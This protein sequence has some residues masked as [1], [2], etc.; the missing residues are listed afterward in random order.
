[1]NDLTP[2]Q[3]ARIREIIREELD[4]IAAERMDQG[5]ADARR[6]AWMRDD[7]RIQTP[8]RGESEGL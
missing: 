7:P 6:D 3:E 5:M 4:R 8:P 2:E 1:M